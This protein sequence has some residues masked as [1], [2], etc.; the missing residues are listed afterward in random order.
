MVVHEHVFTGGSLVRS[1]VRLFV[2]RETVHLRHCRSVGERMVDEE[3]HPATK[4]ELIK[5]M[6]ESQAV[7]QTFQVGIPPQRANALKARKR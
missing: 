4:Q 3:V 6:A 1:F 7:E 2:E 5:R